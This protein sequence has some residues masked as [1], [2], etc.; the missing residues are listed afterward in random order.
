MIRIW[1][2]LVSDSQHSDREYPSHLNDWFIWRP[3]QITALLPGL[4]YACN[5]Q[6][7]I[8][9]DCFQ[10]QRLS[11][12]AV[13]EAS[14]NYLLPGSLPFQ[15]SSDLPYALPD[16]YGL[17]THSSL[18]ILTWSARNTIPSK[19]V[20]FSE[21]GDLN[22]LSWLPSHLVSSRISFKADQPLY[23]GILWF[24]FSRRILC[25]HLAALLSS[26]LVAPLENQVGPICNFA[27][28]PHPRCTL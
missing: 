25:P 12:C 4:V 9:Q 7:P 6:A 16:A 2:I 15:H 10:L 19:R 18:F 20:S 14:Q 8:L 26:N 23:R 27:L 1:K 13:S 21:F 11:L 3:S 24:L 28:M 22:T 17:C 5:E